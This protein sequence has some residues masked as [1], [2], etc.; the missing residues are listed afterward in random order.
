MMPIYFKTIDSTNSYLKRNYQSLDHL[1]WVKSDLQTHGKGRLLNQWIGTKDSL[2]CS[3]ILKDTI[4]INMITR[5]P[6]LAAQS[7]HKTLKKY[8]KDILIKWPNDLYLN[9]KKIAGIL[10]ESI[11]DQSKV[12]ALVIG[13]GI[14]IN[15]PSF[16]EIIEHKATSLYLNTGNIND[17]DKIFQKLIEI[18]STDLNNYM[19]KPLEVIN[20]C[21]DH[22]YLKNKT[23]TYM[24][25]QKL[26]QG[27]VSS[28][29]HDGYL[30]VKNDDQSII[31]DSGEVTL[32]TI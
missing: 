19:K 25:D 9:D 5:M 22:A 6:L 30:V 4:D 1:T 15:Q 24:K 17:K 29:N 12:L 2:L 8:H 23:I 21:N 11:I 14:N 18:F 26:H 3:V 16:P 27:M 10:V 7:L 13:F 31:L 28:I 32:K 20:Y